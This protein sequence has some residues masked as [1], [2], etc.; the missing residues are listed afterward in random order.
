MSPMVKK[1][2]MYKKIDQ[3]LDLVQEI[4]E[5][6]NKIEEAL[7]SEKTGP[8]EAPPAKERK[9]SKGRRSKK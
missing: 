1:S 4:V 5:R 6:Q 8:R 3:I 9:V 2:E 7:S